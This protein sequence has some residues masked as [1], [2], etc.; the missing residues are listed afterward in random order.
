MANLGMTFDTT[1][2]EQMGSFEP[3]PAG[4]YKAVIVDSEMKR[5]K[6]GYGQMLVLKFEVIDGEQK[7]RNFWSRLNLDNPNKTAVEIAQRELATIG[8]AVG[9]KVFTDSSELHNIPMSVTLKV[10]PGSNGYGPSNEVAMYEALGGG[11][12]AQAQQATEQ[13]SPQV[14]KKPWE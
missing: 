8:N 10:S 12:P 7:G 9:K 5:T 6:N 1:Q 4:Q 3:I 13:V 2:H 14:A 11:A